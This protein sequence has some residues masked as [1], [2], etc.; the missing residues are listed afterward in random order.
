M[1]RI[2]LALLILAGG[3]QAAQPLAPMDLFELEYA[4]DAQIS[5]N[6]EQV[7]YVRHFNDVMTDRRYQNLW[8]IDTDG[9][10]NRPLSAGKHSASFPRWSPDG[11]R[12]AYLS[13]ESG[14]GQIHVRWMDTGDT[15]AITS[16]ALPP[17]DIAWS[18]D[19]GRIAFTRLV[20]EP[21]LVIG[22]M[23][24]APDGAEWAPAPK[25]TDKLA[26]RFDHVGEVPPGY[27]H[28]FVVAADGGTP[29]RVTQGERQ[30]G[31]GNFVW[32]PEG[33][34]FIVSADLAEGREMFGAGNPDIHEVSLED[35]SARR[36]IDRDGPDAAVTV[37]PDGRHIAYV[38]YDDRRQGHQQ[39]DLYV[40]DRDGSNVRNLTGTYDRHVQSAARRGGGGPQWAP[41]GRGIHAAV[42]DEGNARLVLFS[43]DGSRRIAA[44]DVG[45]GE[46]GY[47]SHNTLWS[48]S[49]RGRLA[50]TVPGP[51]MPGDVAVADPGRAGR[52]L[53]GLNDDLFAGRELGQV[54][55][56]RWKSSK[57]GRSVHGWIIKPPGFDASRKYPLILE[58]HGGPFADYGDVFDTEKQLM[59]AAGYVVLYTNPRGSISYGE[60]F[61]NLIHHAYPGDD[62][63]DLNAAVDRVIGMGF[64]DE[65]RLYVTGGS[66][67]GVLTA[68]MIG[69]TDR[70]RA[71]VAFYP[72]INWESFIFTADLSGLFLEY[73][74]PG[75][76]WRHRDNFE[77]RSLLKVSENVTTP[78]LI[79]TGEEDWR[80]PMSES[81]Q[82][83]KALKLQG[84]ETVLV[85]VPEE[86]HGIVA[87]PSHAMSKMTTLL[88]W[89]DK[90]SGQP[91]G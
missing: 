85:R 46:M 31:V 64:I 17:G 77:A 68:W 18:P 4:T 60:E 21:P 22:E 59:A 37:S 83:Y 38:G 66:G 63:H 57:D 52:M 15:A 14:S 6:G 5:P 56:L 87:R 69:N 23:P 47:I 27:M 61:G 51:A 78:T 1:I 55:E 74:V 42:H 88:G 86:P 16:G 41:D 9:T 73:W 62:F 89:F 33:E 70:F 76:P 3:A 43:L 8:I 75:L 71:A 30:F 54:E 80:T 79:M 34:S 39:N 29:R 84:V 65:N 25:Y 40:A 82:Y 50:Y 49:D 32:A 91:G 7:V 13:D 72:V 24:P 36:L 45:A 35:G 26:F 90:H 11:S 48:I 20:P 53:T 44:E 19:G 81:E 67:G 12:L 58:M 10:G 28:I 2:S